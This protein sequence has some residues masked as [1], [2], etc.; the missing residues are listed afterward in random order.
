MLSSEKQMGELFFFY[1]IDSDAKGIWSQ[2]KMHQ[3][4]RGVDLTEILRNF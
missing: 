1:D 4:E 3:G 2:R